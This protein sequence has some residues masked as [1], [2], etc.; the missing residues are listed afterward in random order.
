[1]SREATG[2]R[3]DPSLYLG[4]LIHDEVRIA[5]AMGEK[6]DALQ[7]REQAKRAPTRFPAAGDRA[8]LSLN[9]AQLLLE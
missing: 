9:P 2:K 7:R 6:R 4:S 8:E 5:K 3:A 1:M